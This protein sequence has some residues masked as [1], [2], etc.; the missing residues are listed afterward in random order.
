MDSISKGG[1]FPIAISLNKSRQSL[2]SLSFYYTND[3]TD[4]TQ[5]NLKLAPPAISGPPVQG[6]YWAFIPFIYN[7][8]VSDPISTEDAWDTGG[9]TPGTYTICAQADDGYNPVTYCSEIPVQVR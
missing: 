4:P 8:P 2:R 6:D 3:P 9:V 7:G 1:R 5:H